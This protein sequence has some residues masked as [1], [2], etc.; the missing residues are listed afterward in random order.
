[1]STLYGPIEKVGT[2]G[3]C[4][5]NGQITVDASPSLHL[6]RMDFGRQPCSRWTSGITSACCD[7]H[8]DLLLLRPGFDNAVGLNSKH[9]AARPNHGITP[10]WDQIQVI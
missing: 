9:R 3:D 10:M 7:D 8:S 6:F 4:A 2:D 5:L 1:M